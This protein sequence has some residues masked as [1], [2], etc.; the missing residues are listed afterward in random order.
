MKQLTIASILCSLL[1]ACQSKPDLTALVKQH[2]KD[3]I[4]PRF[5]DP[6]SYK[7]DMIDIEDTTWGEQLNKEWEEELYTNVRIAEQRIWLH[8]DDP[9]DTAGI[10]LL[11]DEMAAAEEVLQKAKA[12]PLHRPDSI[13]YV[14]ISVRV[15]GR[16]KTGEVKPGY[17]QLKF[18]PSTNKFLPLG[19]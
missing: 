18:N 12:H 16:K 13:A 2:L 1:Y 8:S 6:S 9:T 4:V 11:K 10:Q 17:I 19:K 14:R 7:F 5:H 15:E 3:S